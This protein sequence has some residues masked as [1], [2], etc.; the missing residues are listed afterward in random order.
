MAVIT[1]VFAPIAPN[2]EATTSYDIQHGFGYYYLLTHLGT[3]DTEQAL[4]PLSR[5]SVSSARYGNWHK[6]KKETSAQKNVP[7]LLVYIMGG[8]TYSEMR[9]AYEV[10]ADKKNWEVIIGECGK[11]F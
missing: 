11:V 2:W 1:S 7:R 8:V 6:D 4:T 10:T 9:A 3:P 5:V